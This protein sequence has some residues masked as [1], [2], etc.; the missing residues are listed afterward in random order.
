MEEKRIKHLCLLIFKENRLF[1]LLKLHFASQ[2][3]SCALVLQ[4]KSKVKAS[5]DRATS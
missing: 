5:P 1:K 4:E 2:N 3:C